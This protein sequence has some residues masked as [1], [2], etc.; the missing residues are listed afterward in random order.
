ME[1]LIVFFFSFRCF[2]T[3]QLLWLSETFQCIIIVLLVLIPADERLIYEK[4]MAFLY[5][6][7]SMTGSQ[8]KYSSIHKTGMMCIWLI[9]T[10]QKDLCLALPPKLPEVPGGD[11]LASLSVIE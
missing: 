9:N 2:H 5:E 11:G 1:N 7:N 3:S 10:K 4:L 6:E 8:G